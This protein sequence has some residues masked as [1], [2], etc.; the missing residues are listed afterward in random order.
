MSSVLKKLIDF[1]VP[2]QA[3]ADTKWLNDLDKMDEISALQFVTQHLS[4]ECSLSRF[5]EAQQLE[6]VLA[7]DQKCHTRLETITFQYSRFEHSNTEV[8]NDLYEAVT[9][10][11]RQ[12]FS[13]YKHL[14]RTYIKMYPEKVIFSTLQMPMLLG[15]AM[16]AAV[17]MNKWRYFHQ[18]TAPAKSWRHINAIYKIAEHE[19]I[20]D[21]NF[22]LYADEEETNIAAMFVQ[23]AMLDTLLQS[24]LSRKQIEISAQLLMK[25]MPD[26]EV[27]E[28][29]IQ[30]KHLF[31]IDLSS[32]SGAKRIRQFEP[33]PGCRY[34]ET[35]ALCEKMTD[36][37]LRIE[38]NQSIKH[39]SLNRLASSQALL[40]VL[41]KLRAEWSRSDYRRQRRQAKRFKVT[42]T[43]SVI[44]GFEPICNQV[45][46]MASATKPVATQY[47]ENGQSLDERLA[48]HRMS[49]ANGPTSFYR[50]TGGENWVVTDE[51]EGGYCALLGREIKPWVKPGVL[52]CFTFPENHNEIVIAEIR[53]VKQQGNG[54]HRVGLE[55]ISKKAVWVQMSCLQHRIE[56]QLTPDYV[57]DYAPSSDMRSAA[58]CGLYI[59]PENG[60]TEKP[61]LII[62][63]TEFQPHTSY[64]IGY[65]DQ[66]ATIQ[67]TTSVREQD[68]WVRLELIKPLY[69]PSFIYSLGFQPPP[70]TLNSSTVETNAA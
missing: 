20:T 1:C 5:S 37:I 52:V 22:N 29:Y 46:T 44:H 30:E 43:A 33:S 39:F 23:A 16:H 24:G 59:P 7:V 12:L 35:D 28:R 34:W 66:E 36:V 69:H 19:S 10:Y 67:L 21:F 13:T 49:S 4:I 15:R 8:E 62:P 70:K 2:Q 41:L 25:W 53:S 47:V 68:D 31:Y 60:I 17:C 14:I 50:G 56:K 61:G 6:E 3:G 42:K 38:N 18:Q 32:D 26:V 51:S 58:F 40:E 55:T 57:V 9:N 65:L 63:L 11:Y 45:R 54:Q 64:R 27:S 48:E